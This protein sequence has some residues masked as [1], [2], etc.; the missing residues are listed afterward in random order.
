MQRPVRLRFAQARSAL[1]AGAVLLASLLG[2]PA[3][4]QTRVVTDDAGH[5]VTIPITPRRIVSLRDEDITAPLMEL[6]ANLVATVGVTSPQV[7]GGRPFVR[8]AFQSL[9]F[10]F[11]QSPVTFVGIGNNFDIEAVAS[12]KPDLIFAPTNA[13]ARREQLMAI[14]PTVMINVGYAAGNTP[15][16]RYR[17]L[18]EYSGRMERFRSAEHL[19][20]L[21]GDF[22]VSIMRWGFAPGTPAEM[23]AQMDKS[24]PAEWRDFLHAPKNRQWLFIDLDMSRTTTFATARWVLDWLMANV[25]MREYA[26]LPATQRNTPVRQ[27]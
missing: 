5:Q 26:P 20:Q 10:R 27:E 14:A 6:G 19:P 21:Q 13:A 17:R 11:E 8:G 23:R 12:A 18:A 15:L 4:A 2:T 16:E 22:L 24:L 25:V 1:L 7:N 9:D 3:S